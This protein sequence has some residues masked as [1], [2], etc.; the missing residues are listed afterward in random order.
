[1]LV[2]DE[3]AVRRLANRILQLSGYTVLEARNGEEAI[4][5]AQEYQGPIHIL[6]T[7]LVMPRMGGKR[8]ATVMTRARPDLR[9]L[10]MS[11]YAEEPLPRPEARESSVAFL[12]KPF[13]PLGL[14]RKVREVLDVREARRARSSSWMKQRG[15]WLTISYDELKHAAAVARIEALRGLRRGYLSCPLA[16]SSTAPSTRLDMSL[17][18]N[19][20]GM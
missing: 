3:E 2:E 14:T 19:D 18:G 9:V 4:A 16:C 20:G 5:V 13:S 15:R 1:L 7:D 12:Q 10:F 17:T 11:G 8:L 6:L